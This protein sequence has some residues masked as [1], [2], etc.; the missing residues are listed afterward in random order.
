VYPAATPAPES[1][2]LFESLYSSADIK[3]EGS[4][5]SGSNTVG[6]RGLVAGTAYKAHVTVKDTAGN[7]STVWTS[8]AF[9]PGY[10]IGDSGPA[11]GLICYV[12]LDGFRSYGVICHYLEA[13]PADLGDY[14]WGGNGTSCDATATDIGT[15]AAN[16][17]V[18]TASGHS[19]THFAARTCAGYSY[20]GYS[21]W[22]LPS[23][24]ELALMYTNLKAQELG[25]FSSTYYWSSSENASNYALGQDFADGYQFNLGKNVEHSVRT[26]RAF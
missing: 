11:G 3:A 2:S 18:L 9:T 15:G 7:Y 17:A 26:V 19:H 20:G 1:G 6:L 5:A 8:E 4:A 16:T 12:N 14:Q 24:D 22:F 25:G 13:A 10:E 21:D 23:K